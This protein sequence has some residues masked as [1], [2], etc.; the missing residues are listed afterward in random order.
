MRI[1]HA[2]MAPFS[3]P[4]AYGTRKG[5]YLHLVTECGNEVTSESSP[6]EGFSHECLVD[7]EHEL[8]QIVPHLKG[9]EIPAFLSAHTLPTKFAANTWALYTALVELKEPRQPSLVSSAG[10][11]DP[12]LPLRLQTFQACKS[13]KIK[14]A[15]LSLTDALTFFNTHYESL[16]PFKLRLDC[17]QKW[18]LSQVH[19]LLEKLPP[20]IVEYIEEPLCDEMTSPYPLAADESLRGVG[21]PFSADVWVVKPMLSP[22]LIEAWQKSSAPLDLILSSSY[23]TQVGL[24][25]LHKWC[26]RLSLT[27]RCMG[28]DTLKLF[29]SMEA[30]HE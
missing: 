16:R 11:L 4:Y 10:Y 30:C 24:S 3:L 7:V 5:Y 18:R 25:H 8:L 21:K 29:T 15:P 13:V 20:L 17:N 22:Y 1:A 14:L 9:Y 12:A 19:A 2:H 23:E 28:L 26:H 6:L 27:T